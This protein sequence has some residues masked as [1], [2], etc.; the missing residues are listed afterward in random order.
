MCGWFSAED[1]LFADNMTITCHHRMSKER[2]VIIHGRLSGGQPCTHPLILPDVS[3][4]DPRAMFW[5]SFHLAQT[6]D[7]LITDVC[8]N[9]A[10]T[11]VAQKVTGHESL[12][13]QADH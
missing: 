8:K 2:N 7:T 13:T 11:E 3:A 6:E 12:W 5:N 9:A 4:N 10:N 1:I